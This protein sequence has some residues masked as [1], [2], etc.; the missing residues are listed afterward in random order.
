MNARLLRPV[1]LALLIGLSAVA[2]A[3]AGTEEPRGV[4]HQLRIYE[5]F[6][7]NKQAFHDRFR[8]HA[9]RIMA[10]YGFRIVTMWEAVHGSRTEFVYLLEW[11]DRQTMID[12]WAKFM[13]DEE[14]AAIKAD[15]ARAH[16]KLVGEIQERIMEKT[17][18]SPLASSGMAPCCLLPPLP[19]GA[20]APEQSV[21]TSR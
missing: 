19:S 14:W 3:S 9:V 17:N 6:D 18:Y 20:A 5:I 7:H 13:A 12:R 15:S 11:P 4:I 2:T 10:K 1:A 8:D 16:G 21:S